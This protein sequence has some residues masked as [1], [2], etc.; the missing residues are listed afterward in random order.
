MT[1]PAGLHQKTFLLLLAAVSIAFFWILLPFY[2]AVFWGAVL[3]IIFAPL[4]RRLTLRLR[5]RNNVAALLTL[6]LVLVLVILPLTIISG[7]LINQGVSLYDSIRSGQLNFG[8]YFQRA[9][10]ALP[11]YLRM[12]L[13]KVDLTSIAD[14]QAKLSASALQASQFVATRALSIG[15]NTAQFMISFGIMLYLLFFLLRDG[16]QL[17][18]RIREAVPLSQSYKQHL[19]QKFTTVV[20]ATVKGNVAVAIVQGML[21]GGIFAALGI[22]GALLW[23]VVMAFLSLLPAVGAS[24]IWGPVA[25]YFLL[26]GSTLKGFVL[27]AF[28]MLVIGMVDNVLRPILVGKDTQMPDYVVLISTLGGMAL[29]GLN[30]FVIGPLVAALFIACWDLHTHGDD[31]GPAA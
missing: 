29:F 16:Q 26:T 13:A 19:S 4:Q 6:L 15:Q 14:V 27:I 31:D 25:I 30:G 8:L 22:Q 3:A 17:S 9:V 23:S 10:D 7:S 18:R 12:L 2:G 28:G 20:R 11:P 24:L 5:G 21:G 1:E